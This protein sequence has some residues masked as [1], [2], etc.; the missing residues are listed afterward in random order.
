[1]ISPP[2]NLLRHFSAASTR[3]TWTWKADSRFFHAICHTDPFLDPPFVSCQIQCTDTIS[4]TE[5]PCCTV[6]G[7]ASLSFQKWV[8][9]PSLLLSLLRTSLSTL[10]KGSSSDGQA[11]PPSRSRS[12]HLWDNQAWIAVAL[13]LYGGCVQ[14]RGMK[15]VNISRG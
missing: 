13:K 4:E 7:L 1:M 8:F 9:G 10:T 14:E 3:K 6:N 2:L 12:S 11:L 15:T 5:H